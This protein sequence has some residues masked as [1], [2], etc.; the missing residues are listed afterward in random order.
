MAGFIHV[1]PLDTDAS[2]TGATM[3]LSDLRRGADIIVS[4]AVDAWSG[5]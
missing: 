5:S 1:P 3:L 2:A 4:A